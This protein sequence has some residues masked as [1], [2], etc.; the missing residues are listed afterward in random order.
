M[1]GAICEFRLGTGTFKLQR[2]TIVSSPFGNSISRID[3]N[4][5]DRVEKTVLVRKLHEAIGLT[6]DVERRQMYFSDLCG[7]VY[8]AKMDGSD[9]KVLLPDVGDLTGMASCSLEQPAE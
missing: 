4:D 7:A 8:T 2:L 9:E 3:L 6:L 5:H 1:T